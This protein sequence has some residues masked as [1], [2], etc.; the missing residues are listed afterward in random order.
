MGRDFTFNT[1][2]SVDLGNS[3]DRQLVR[4][5]L[6]VE[7]VTSCVVLPSTEAEDE[8]F[9]GC[10]IQEPVATSESQ[11]EGGLTKEDE[12][13]EE[14]EMTFPGA[15]PIE[16]DVDVASD[17]PASELL[18]KATHLLL[19]LVQV[20][21]QRKGVEA[22]PP[23]PCPTVERPFLYGLE[24]SFSRFVAYLLDW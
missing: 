11:S 12:E 6:Q 15:Y 9:I 23:V 1:T 19:D 5:E 22:N 16:Q 14:K 10:D 21:V 17:E 4:E 7:S 3:N 8:V 18:A 20:V 24:K 2:A 13:G